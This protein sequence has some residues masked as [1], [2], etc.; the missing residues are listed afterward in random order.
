MH[1]D[2]TLRVA[3]ENGRTSAPVMAYE[4]KASSSPS[5][6]EALIGVKF[7]VTKGAMPTLWPAVEDFTVLVCPMRSQRQNPTVKLGT[8]EDCRACRIQPVRG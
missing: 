8:N 7:C 6:L 5:S 4:M 3:A 1:N 2:V